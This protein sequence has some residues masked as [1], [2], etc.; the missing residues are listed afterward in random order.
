MSMIKIFTFAAALVCA[1]IIAVPAGEKAGKGDRPGKM[2]IEDRLERIND[3]PKKVERLDTN[4]NGV[5]DE[6]ELRAAHEA[7]LAKYDSD[8]DGKLSE[9]ERAVMR[10]DRIVAVCQRLEAKQAEGKTKKFDR[11][12]AN[13][14][15][16]LSDDEIIPYLRAH[17][18]HGKH[19]Q[20]RQNKA[21]N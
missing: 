21:V 14:D 16:S 4:G 11:V 5:V 2:S 17:K 9:D 10:A 13:G 1:S 18:K 20:A 19:K 12:D 8:G 15:G 7:R 6:A 3:C